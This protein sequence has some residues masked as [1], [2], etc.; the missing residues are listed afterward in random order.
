MQKNLRQSLKQ[1]LQC[2]PV[3]LVDIIIEYHETRPSWIKILLAGDA[4]VGK[5]SMLKAFTT[6]SIPSSYEPTMG[7]D[8]DKK[9]IEL[10]KIPLK[11]QIWEY[12]GDERFRIVAGRPVHGFSGVVLV[13]D[14]TDRESFLSIPQWVSEVDWRFTA[15]FN[16]T[17]F[18]VGNKLDREKDRQVSFD[19]GKA[20]ANARGWRFMERSATEARTVVS[21]FQDMARVVIYGQP[22]EE[23]SAPTTCSCCVL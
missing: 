7:L 6:A 20:F 17:V 12:G 18:L 22:S 3:N 5:T 11:L 14:V 19:E 1:H 10:N 4:K 16:S 9:T 21:L 8:F 13:Y 15:L 2:L 23:T